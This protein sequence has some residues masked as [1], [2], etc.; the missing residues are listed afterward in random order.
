[1]STRKTYHE[2]QNDRQQLLKQRP[3]M[4]HNNSLVAVNPERVTTLL[5]LAIEHYGKKCARCGNAKDLCVHHRHYRTVGFEQPERDI[6]LLCWDCHTDLHT[7]SKQKRL[8]KDDI[9][10]VD[11]QWGSSLKE[12]LPKASEESASGTTVRS[13][14]I[15]FVLYRD[16]AGQDWVLCEP[17][18]D[19][20]NPALEFPGLV[21]RCDFAEM[22]EYQYVTRLTWEEYHSS[23]VELSPGTQDVTQHPKF[24]RWLP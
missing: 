3:G 9:P 14:A 8:N 6:V 15:Y 24:F 21:E 1:M 10:F 2:Y 4:R 18:K 20:F 11:P 17:L 12:H 5:K 23:Y 7:R 16:K 19:C 13:V 22:V